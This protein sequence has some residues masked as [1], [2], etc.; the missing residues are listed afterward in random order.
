MS[1][2]GDRGGR[3]PGQTGPMT[4]IS[5]EELTGCPLELDF[6]C[7][8]GKTSKLLETVPVS[9]TFNLL[10]VGYRWPFWT[11]VHSTVSWISYLLTCSISFPGF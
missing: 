6:V 11:L 10:V 5:K 4:S 3:G 9:A 8:C 1:V 2:L 7:I